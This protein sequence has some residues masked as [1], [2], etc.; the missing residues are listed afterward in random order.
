MEAAGRP[1]FGALLRQFRLDAG[2]TQ[3]ELA[4]RAKLSVE[5]IGTLERGARTRPYR[6]TVVLLGRALGL[7]PEREALLRS[8]VGIAHPDRQQERSETLN[9]SLL[10]LVRPDVQATPRHNLPQ[11]LTSFVGRR[12]EVCE[13]AALLREHCLVTLVGTG[14]VGKTRIAVHLGSELSDG[15]PDGA[16]LIDLAPLADQS[17]VASAVLTALQLPFTSGSALGSVVA[18]IKTRRLLLIL[19]NCEHVIA[20]VSGLAAA[21]VTSCPAVRVLATSREPF[22]VAGEQA[23]RL[24]SL[25]VPLD[26]TVSPQDALAYGAVTLFVDRARAVDANFALTDDNTPDVAEICRRLDGIPLAIELAAA[27][28]KVLSPRQ[29]AARLDQ[30]FRLLTGGD[31]R[32]LPRHQTMT[33]L[34]DW[35]YDLL[36]PREQQFFESLSVFAGGCTLEA[37]TAV[38]AGQDEDDIQIV[39]LLGSLVTK[40]LLLAELAGSEQRYRLLESTRQ[41]ARSKLVARGEQERVARRHALAYLDLA[42]RLEGARETTADR[43]WLPKATPELENWRAG[44]DWALGERHDVILGQRLAAMRSVVWQTFTPAEARRWIRAA[45]ASVD[46]CTPASLIARLEHA[47]ADGASQFGSKQALSSAQRAMR[48]Y[49]TLGDA[50]GFAQAQHLA[51]GV[52]VRL[53]STDEGEALERDAL[54]AARALGNRRLAL[55]AL[56]GLGV[57]RANARDFA[58]SRARLIEARELAKVL[59]ADSY[60]APIAVNL[61]STEFESGDPEAALRISIDLLATHRASKPAPHLAETL[62]AAYCNTAGY[63]IA[64][65]RYDEARAQANEALEFGRGAG[66]TVFVALSLWHLAAM[67]LRFPIEGRRTSADCRVAGRLLGFV[68]TSRKT[69]GFDADD[70]EYDNAVALLG[71]AVGTEES[72]QLLALGATMT[73][74]EAIAQAQAVSRAMDS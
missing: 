61:A 66:L 52:L 31:P 53:G 30:R 68:G 60:A 42:E 39:D 16:W 48:R 73:E 2:M 6:E 50:L 10:R 15:C 74:D 4:E 70:S 49:R 55:N 13:I 20:E 63:L 57:A 26:S 37:A 9:A 19:D 24:P 43:E 51:G 54:E 47:D 1:H 38:C 14:G 32:V 67:V 28:T 36:S 22:N 3:Q 64:L 58:G 7:S 12:R 29:I 34:L 59:G 71:E 41:Y 69:L 8:A 23:Y 65:G 44:L 25:A 72:M 45:L 17:L 46:E 27:R 21:I 62:G 18:Y 56:L 5:A 40:S 35:S 11:Q 33:A